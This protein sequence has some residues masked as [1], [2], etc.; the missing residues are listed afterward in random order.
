MTLTDRE[1]A[2]VTDEVYDCMNDAH[3]HDL[4]HIVYIY[5]DY[6]NDYGAYA[7]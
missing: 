6:F 5:L 4:M 3:T 7:E 1:L 2:I